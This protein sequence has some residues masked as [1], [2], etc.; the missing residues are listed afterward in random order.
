MR[1]APISTNNLPICFYVQIIINFF[2]RNDSPGQFA[3]DHDILQ[4]AIKQ[5][6]AFRVRKAFDLQHDEDEPLKCAERGNDRKRVTCCRQQG[7]WGY[8]YRPAIRSIRLGP[9]IWIACRTTARRP[10]SLA[11]TRNPSSPSTYSSSAL[12]KHVSAIPW[13]AVTRRE[14]RN[15][16][17]VR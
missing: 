6:R 17:F 4:S 1:E 8:G 7:M 16:Q 3:S 14:S 15:R 2:R 5:T 12:E 11:Q 13:S 10:S 9:Y